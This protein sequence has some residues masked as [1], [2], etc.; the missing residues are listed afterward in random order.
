MIVSLCPLYHAKVQVPLKILLYTNFLFST[1]KLHTNAYDD[2]GTPS[3]TTTYTNNYDDDVDN[4]N[5]NNNINDKQIIKRAITFLIKC[6]N[7]LLI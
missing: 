1:P 6:I 4:N 7:M 3:K 2:D 5:H